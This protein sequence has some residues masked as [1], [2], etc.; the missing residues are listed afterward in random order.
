MEADEEQARRQ[1]PQRTKAIG[2]EGGKKKET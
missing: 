1:H 2:K